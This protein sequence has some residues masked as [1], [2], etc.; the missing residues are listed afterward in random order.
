[1]TRMK[2]AYLKGENRTVSVRLTIYIVSIAKELWHTWINGSSHRF[3]LLM[4]LSVKYTENNETVR[5]ISLSYKTSG[6]VVRLCNEDT[7]WRDNVHFFIH[8][9]EVA[10][11]SLNLSP[12]WNTSVPL[13]KTYDVSF[14]FKHG[15]KSFNFRT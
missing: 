10:C 4:L 13:F 15:D 14:C 8:P 5:E 11:I 3:F 9:A 1:M 6:S 7:F 2:F 12:V